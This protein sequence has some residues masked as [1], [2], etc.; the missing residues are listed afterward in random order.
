MGRDIIGPSEAEIRAQYADEDEAEIAVS[1]ARYDMW[2]RCFL[3]CAD[4]RFQLP[5]RKDFDAAL[6]REAKALKKKESAP[7]PAL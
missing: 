4:V 3:R 1:S 6:A 2:V 5:T 7:S